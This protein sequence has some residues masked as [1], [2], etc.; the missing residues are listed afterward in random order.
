MARNVLCTTEHVGLSSASGTYLL[1]LS[2][3]RFKRDLDLPF[4]AALQVNNWGCM[5]DEEVT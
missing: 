3:L 4:R 2:R 1:S 5:A